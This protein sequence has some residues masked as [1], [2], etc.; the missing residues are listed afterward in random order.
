MKLK[1]GIP[2]GSLQEATIRMFKKAGFSVSVNDRSYFPSVDDD[3][4]SLT[5][6]RA[7]EMSRYVEDGI[8]DCGIT[9]NDWIL[10]NNSKVVRVAELI[11]AKHSIRP[12]KWVLAVPEGSR[13]RSVRDLNG[14]RVATELVNVTKEYFKKNKTKANVEFN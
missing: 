10:E 6:F 14:K 9:G 11:Y 13:I 3:E 7:Q 1:L 12:V 2:K 8:L 5:M 4:I